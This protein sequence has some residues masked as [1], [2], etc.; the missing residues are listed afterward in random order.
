MTFRTL[1]G[2]PDPFGEPQRGKPYDSELSLVDVGPEPELTRRV[3]E[4]LDPWFEIERNVT[5]QHCSGRRLCVDAIIS[6]R[7]RDRWR[8]PDV[9]LG[10]EFKVPDQSILSATP[11]LTGRSTAD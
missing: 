8:D 2:E 4:R 11:T 10:V 6:P 1:V 9:A 7:D 3:L 5:G